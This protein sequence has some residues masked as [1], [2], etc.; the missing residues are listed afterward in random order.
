MAIATHCTVN[1]MRIS[2]EFVGISF[3]IKGQ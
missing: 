1:C 3:A 2:R